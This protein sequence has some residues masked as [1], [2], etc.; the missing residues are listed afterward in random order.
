MA[1][2]VPWQQLETRVDEYLSYLTRKWSALPDSAAEWESWDE[3]S[4][5][6]FVI[7]WGVP[8]DRLA[9]LRGWEAAGQLTPVQRDRYTS[10]LKLVE[11]YQSILDRLLAD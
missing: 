8:A 11:Q 10:L 7:E 1:D 3:G 4:Q 2:V 6:A 5:L 9:Q